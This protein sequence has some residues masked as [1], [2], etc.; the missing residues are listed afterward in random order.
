M[1]KIELHFGEL[2]LTNK[3]IKRLAE[4]GYTPETLQNEVK[5][6]YRQTGTPAVYVGTFGK[7]NNCS[8]CG[9]WVHPSTFEDFDGFV[10]FCKA[11]HADEGANECELMIQDFD[12][13]P[14]ISVDEVPN[15]QDFD[16]MNEYVELCNEYNKEAVDTYVQLD[17]KLSE[18]ADRYEGEYDSEEDFARILVDECYDLDE[19]MGNFATYFDYAHFARDLFMGDYIYDN[20]FVFSNF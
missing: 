2:E 18:F 16:D 4:L 11:I 6:Q 19:K 17:Y 12:N 5:K 7:Y 1:N 13:Y 10:T 14:A 9:L 8:V 3:V 20:G 15:E